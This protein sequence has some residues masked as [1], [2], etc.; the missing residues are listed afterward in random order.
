MDKDHLGK[1]KPRPLPTAPA[2]PIQRPNTPVDVRN[3]NPNVT[4]PQPSPGLTGPYSSANPPP[5]PS[6][7]KHVAGSSHTTYIAPPPPNTEAGKPPSYNETGQSVRFA[8]ENEFRE[9]QLVLTEPIGES[10]SM[11]IENTI[12]GAQ[13]QDGWEANWDDPPSFTFRSLDVAI[14]GRSSYEETHWWRPDNR[15][16]SGRPGPGILPPM[17]AEQVHDSDHALFN[18]SLISPQIAT[19]T[20]SSSRSTTSTPAPSQ[21]GGGGGRGPTPSPRPS[22]P[23]P[24]SDDEVRSAVPHPNAFYCPRE[25]SWILLSWHQSS[26]PPPLAPSCEHQG[27]IINLFDRDNRTGLLNCANAKDFN[28]T[29]HFHKFPAALDSTQVLVPPYRTDVWDAPETRK[30]KRRVGAL[31]PPD[32][33]QTEHERIRARTPEPGSDEDEE[34]APA[35]LLDLYACCQCQV[36]C[37]ASDS[38]SGIIPGPVWQE[39]VRDKRANPS[40]GKTGE[41]TLVTSLETILTAIENKLWQRQDRQLKISSPSFQKRLGFNPN[42]KSL[43]EAIG[44][45]EERRDNDATLRSPATDPQ[46]PQGALNRARLLRA[47]VEIGAFLTDFVKAR[48]ANIEPT[49]KDGNGHPLWIRLDPCRDLIL[50][51]IGAHPDQIPRQNLSEALQIT[52]SSLH[53]YLETLGL[54][55]SIFTQTFVAFAY[56]AQCRCDPAR[57]PAYFTALYKLQ[58]YLAADHHAT[59]VLQELIISEQSRG[60]FTEDEIQEALTILGFGPN[61]PLGIDYEPSIEDG[62]IMNAWKAVHKNALVAPESEVDTIVRNA[63]EALKILAELRGSVPL[64]KLWEDW[65]YRTVMTLTKAYDTLGVHSTMDDDVLVTVFQ[66]RYEESMTYG[67]ERMRDALNVI[68]DARDSPRLKQFYETGVDPGVILPVISPDLPRGLNQL[69]N[70]C[71]LNSLLQYFYTIKDLRD[72][73]LPMSTVDLKEVEDDKLTDDILNQH[74]V[75]GRN[76]TRREIIRSRKFVSQLAQLF[77]N[78]EMD[79]APSITPSIELAKLALVTSKDEEEDD[80]AQTGTD[81]SSNDTDATLVED[82]SAPKPRLESTDMDVDVIVTSPTR[83]DEESFVLVPEAGGSSPPDKESDVDMENVA[84]KPSGSEQRPLPPPPPPR[85]ND[86]SADDSGM[87]FGRQHDVSECM[88]NVMFQIEAAMLRLE[89]K[90]DGDEEMERSIVKRL[91]YGKL[92]QQVALQAASD[93]NPRKARQSVH[94]K[95]EVFSQL[96]INVAEDGIDVYDGLT[97]CLND[98]VELEGRKGRMERTIVDPPPLLQVQ[99]QRVQFDRDTLQAYK[100]QA[101]VRLDETIY[102]DRFLDESPLDRRAK[103]KELQLLLAEKRERLRTLLN[104]YK[105]VPY[106]EGLENTH[107]ILLE[108]HDLPGVDEELLNAVLS[109][110]QLLHQDIDNLRSEVHQLKTNLEAVW[111]SPDA[112]KYPYELT[113]VFIHRGQS[114]A[115]GHYFFYARNLPSRPDEWFRYNDESVQIVSKEEVLADTTGTNA[116]PY[117]LVF[118]RKGSNVVDTVHRFEESTAE[119]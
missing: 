59:D 42:I 91:F 82:G 98:T 83:D 15:V 108:H 46:T 52:M 3:N 77:Y 101:Y 78:L 114:A 53:P 70:T 56:F 37:I 97:E 30:K 24:P 99:L 40:P 65:R 12:W 90:D 58:Y 35:K 112:Q 113:S 4:S 102:L 54:T 33:V 94:R 119:P 13:S 61:G 18:V 25:N 79:S 44:F 67:K 27:D 47:W 86:Y 89:S 19:S 105:N 75:G 92:H 111:N 34:E 60:R 116:N 100:S 10:P 96:I 107:K 76:V 68:A 84:P 62:F 109:E 50:A 85:R 31:V 1:P 73:V 7:T 2:V 41:T 93:A 64:K 14:Q 29:H 80:A 88:D 5:L 22:Q 66:L 17:L 55:P 110:R 20:P 81:H 72:A 104:G 48:R 28:L 23:P 71:Y 118:A 51:A 21:E 32:G 6:R 39:F 117:L 106:S 8:D 95:E 16:G 57:T 74:R 26:Q 36:Y 49:G 11:H 103:G 63:N 9:P 69:G 38:L 115:F 87:M 43:F 45:T